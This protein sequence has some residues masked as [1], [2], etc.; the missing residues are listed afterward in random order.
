[1]YSLCCLKNTFLLFAHP[2]CKP[3]LGRPVASA[4]S[5]E[6]AYAQSSLANSYTSAVQRMA[7]QRQGVGVKLEK[8]VQAQLLTE[9]V[10]TYTYAQPVPFCRLQLPNTCFL[11]FFLPFLCNFWHFS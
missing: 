10:D 5:P 6:H 4:T 9:V 8:I 1:M 7:V 3:S 2:T 11:S